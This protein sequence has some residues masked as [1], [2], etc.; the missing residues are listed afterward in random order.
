MT[1]VMSACDSSQRAGLVTRICVQNSLYVSH[2]QAIMTA[3]VAKR[4]RHS[5]SPSTEGEPLAPQ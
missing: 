1:P 4:N 3:G 2:M 5:L